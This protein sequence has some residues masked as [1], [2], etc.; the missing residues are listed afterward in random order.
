MVKKPTMGKA[1]KPITPRKKIKAQLPVVESAI[2]TETQ[3]G[4]VIGILMICAV[5]LLVVF[6]SSL[7]AGIIA[8]SGSAPLETI[9][10]RNDYD[11]NYFP[12][13]ESFTFLY[14][15]IN[16]VKYFNVY[17]KS[18]ASYGNFRNTDMCLIDVCIGTKCSVRRVSSCANGENNCRLQEAFVFNEG[19]YSMG[20]RTRV[21]N[22][23]YNCPNGCNDGACAKP[24][25]CI[26]SDNGDPFVKGRT[27]INS[28]NSYVDDICLSGSTSTSTLL[29]STCWS[30]NIGRIRTQRIECENGCVDGFC[31]R[32]KTRPNINYLRLANSQF[33]H[34]VMNF[35]RFEI[36]A[37][38]G[39]D[40]S[41]KSIRF[42]FEKSPN[43]SFQSSTIYLYEDGGGV[44]KLNSVGASAAGTLESSESFVNIVLDNEQIIKKNTTSTYFLQGTIL[45]DENNIR[46]QTYSLKT[47]ISGPLVY[48]GA[49]VSYADLLDKENVFIWSDLSGTNGDGVHSTTSNDWFGSYGIN[50]PSNWW[51]LY[52]L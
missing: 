42:I 43:F 30:P 23:A 44:R 24:I 17:Q 3:S 5:A 32:Q 9:E 38:A 26:D 25:I 40:L 20:G 4:I 2:A 47:K 29:E 8:I 45:I 18:T 11:P 16:N 41:W 46:G 21:G 19:R 6:G 39:G 22:W 49:G 33:A 36:G 10:R 50:I 14:G 27:Q 48:S 7:M 15:N 37:G 28:T 31:I 35:A 51:T 1:L 34:S 52:S 13:I 12:R